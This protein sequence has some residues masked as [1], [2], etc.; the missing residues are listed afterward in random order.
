MSDD[1]FKSQDNLY[2]A[3][4]RSS[5]MV[6]IENLLKLSLLHDDF[7]TYEKAKIMVLKHA[8]ELNES[9]SSY[10]YAS[11]V[12]L[13]V[14]HPIVVIKSTKEN[15][16]KNQEEIATI[17]YPFVMIKEGNNSTFDACTMQQCFS[18]NNKLEEVI[19]EIETIN[20]KIEFK[21]D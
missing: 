20:K 11:K 4:Y 19:K 13:M 15:L 7:N 6:M 17:K 16:L 21:K 14:Q 5:M 9:P 8:K 3:S 1:G 12:A 10:A 18:S 2:D